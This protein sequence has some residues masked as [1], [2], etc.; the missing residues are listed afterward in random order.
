[1]YYCIVKKS[2]SFISLLPVALILIATALVCYLTTPIYPYLPIFLAAIGIAFSLWLLPRA[3][4]CE[5]EYNIEGDLFTVSIIRNKS[6]RK[7]LF[8][9]DISNLVSCAPFDEADKSASVSQKIN[10]SVSENTLY[11]ALFSEDE[12]TTS[13][14]FSPDDEFINSLRL[15]A[16]R[17]VKCNILH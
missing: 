15:L 3:T 16:P 17:K 1:M 11:Y 12:T 5:Y 14:L 13:L 10:A 4:K 8:S 6:S 9:T 2:M 7:V